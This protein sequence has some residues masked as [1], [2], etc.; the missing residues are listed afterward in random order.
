MPDKDMERQRW[1]EK[2]MNKKRWIDKRKRWRD[3]EMEMDRTRWTD[4]D[5]ER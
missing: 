2:V 3:Q 1:R 5:M 4:N